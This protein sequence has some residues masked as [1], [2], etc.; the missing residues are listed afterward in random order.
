MIEL[1]FILGLAGLGVFLIFWAADDIVNDFIERIVGII[2]I[3][4]VIYAIVWAIRWL[5]M[6]GLMV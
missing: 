5:L 1:I 6:G 3:G 4:A 2:G